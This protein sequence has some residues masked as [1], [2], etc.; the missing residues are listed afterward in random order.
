MRI[1]RKKISANRRN[2]AKS[3][4]PKTARGKKRASAN[5]RRH[6]LAAITGRD[7]AATAERERIAKLIC[8]E[9]ASPLQHEQALMF[10]D[11]Q[12]LLRRVREVSLAMIERAETVV[13]DPI[14][15]A[16]GEPGAPLLASTDPPLPADL[17]REAETWRRALPGLMKLDRYMQRALSLRRRAIRN[18][19]A[20][21][22]APRVT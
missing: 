20:M 15:A 9:G 13:L 18:L 14:A 2:S 19:I 6:G 10:A 11:S 7:P 16:T 3:T 21:S 12:L 1:S 8:P 22:H 4:G 17:L 5:A